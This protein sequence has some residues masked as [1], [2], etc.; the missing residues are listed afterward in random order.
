MDPRET[1]TSVQQLSFAFAGNASNGLTLRREPQRE[2]V[3]RLGVELGLPLGTHCEVVL[4]T[5]IQVRGLLAFDEE[6]PSIQLRARCEAPHRRSHLLHRR[7][8]RLRSPRLKLRD[9]A[10]SSQPTAFFRSAAPHLRGARRPPHGQLG[11]SDP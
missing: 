9:R 10:W 6:G 8:R 4:A 2:M 11:R 7:D 1:N 3:R 5:G